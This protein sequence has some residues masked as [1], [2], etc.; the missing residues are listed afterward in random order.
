MA[1]ERFDNLRG[2]SLLG[3]GA[4]GHTRVVVDIVRL[5]GAE[6]SGLV[7]HPSRAA[8]LAG[9]LP[10]LIGTDDDLAS[11]FAAGHALAFVGV[12]IVRASQARQRLYE[13]CRG[14]GFRLPPLVHPSAIVASDAVIEEGAQLM[15]LSVVNPGARVGANTIIN[16]GAIVEHDCD[17]GDH[18][19]IAPRACLCAGVRVGH[20]AHIGS[21]AVVIQSCRIGDGATVAA[22]AV[23]VRD[24]P[25]GATVVGVPARVR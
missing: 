16:T 1:Q 23:V 9:D 13:L 20:A 3:L 14:V 2:R 8:A 25:D 24:V 18:S 19:H 17:V 11:L 10:P 21:G 6:V 15:A 5:R 4:G 12:G 22:G 7:E